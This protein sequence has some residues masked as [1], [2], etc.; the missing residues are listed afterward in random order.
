MNTAGLEWFGP[1]ER[2]TLRP[3]CVVLPS[4][5]REGVRE[6]LC[7]SSAESRESLRICVLAGVL[8]LL[9]VQGEH[10]HRAGP[11]H[12]DPAMYYKL[13]FGLQCLRSGDLVVGFRA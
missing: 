10:V 11:R 9:Y 12:V 1:P 3:L 13:Y 8:S 6:S 2:N 4:L 7:V 5:E